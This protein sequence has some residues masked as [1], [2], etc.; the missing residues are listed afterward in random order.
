MTRSSHHRAWQACLAMLLA[1]LAWPAFA[2]DLKV[3]TWLQDASGV[4]DAPIRVRAWLPP[5]YAATQARYPVVYANDGQDMEAVGLEGSL[6]TLYAAGAIQR[7]IVVAIDMPS[8]RMAAYGVFDRASGSTRL[9]ATR[10]GPVGARAEAYARWLVETLVPAVDARFRTLARP[11]G[12]SLL[13]WSL[14][15]ASAFA[16]GWQYPEVFGQV[17]ALSPSFW[18]AADG[19]D[20]ASLQATRLAHVLVDGSPPGTRPRVFIAVGDAEETDDR[21]GDGVIDV[22]DDARDLVDGWRRPDGSQQ[23]GLRQLGLPANHAAS[24]RRSREPVAL[25]ELAGGRH[26]QASWARM[27]PLFLR[28]ACPTRPPSPKAD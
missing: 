20:A 8:D 2:S 5:D 16:I 12:R 18:L 7:V 1:W 21:D 22:V 25:Y 14:G 26:D 9:A 28:W 13:G 15:A 17:G 6:R 27:L 4:S 10:Y 11:E 3:E 19:R 24:V 23:R